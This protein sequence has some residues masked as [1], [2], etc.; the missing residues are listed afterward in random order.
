V[1]KLG[2]FLGAVLG[3]AIVWTFTEW[4]YVNTFAGSVSD[5]VEVVIT[6]AAAVIGWLV[7]SQ[8][9]RRLGNRSPGAV[10]H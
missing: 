10:E 9:V 3:I 4:L 2:G 7:G 8:L 6:V 5:S 1:I